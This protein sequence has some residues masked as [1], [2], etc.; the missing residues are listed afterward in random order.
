MTSTAEWQVALDVSK[1]RRWQDEGLSQNNRL[2]RL[3][4]YLGLYVVAREHLAHCGI[5]DAVIGVDHWFEKAFVTNEAAETY[6][7]EWR[8]EW[9]TEDQISYDGPFIIPPPKTRP[10]VIATSIDNEIPF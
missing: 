8:A 6:C 7:E 5:T 10:P 3:A 9:E 2:V 4:S 1:A